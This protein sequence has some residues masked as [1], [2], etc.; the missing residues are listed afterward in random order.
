MN[1]DR[2][3]D[4]DP[5]D[6]LYEAMISLCGSVAGLL[7]KSVCA[8]RSNGSHGELLRLA[9]QHELTG[10]LGACERQ[11]RVR[12]LDANGSLDGARRSHLV[13][14]ARNTWALAQLEEITAAFAAHGVRVMALKG[15]AA[16]LWLYDD[17]GLRSLSDLDLLVEEAALPAVRRTM[18]E[19]GYVQQGGYN[20]SE[21]ELLHV[22]RSHL[23]PYVKPG[24]LPVEI[25]CGVLDGRGK[26]ELAAPEMWAASV[27][28]PCGRAILWRPCAAHFLLH[29]AVHFAKHLSGEGFAALKFVADMILLVRRHG[30][31]TDW[32]AFWQTA[33]RWGVTDDVAEVMATLNHHWG[34]VVPIPIP[35]VPPVP[36]RMLVYGRERR[37]LC[38]AAAT[39]RGYLRRVGDFRGLP[40]V[41]AK[42]RY[43]FRLLFPQPANLRWRYQLAEGTALAPYYLLHPLTRM[44]RFARALAA[45]VRSSF[46]RR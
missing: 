22:R 26:D 43:L 46:S 45:M 27:P 32:H 37:A 44:G 12:T 38:N 41:K 36:A 8:G 28:A 9:E 15:A 20:S 6:P 34:L 23:F 30:A 16:L 35:R 1:R 19:L 42:L 31:Q 3:R 2:R 40:G 5:C 33:E 7:G 17:I 25:H 4:L 10:L 18:A 21:D 29:A 24:R 13:Q 39:F 11:W 14:V